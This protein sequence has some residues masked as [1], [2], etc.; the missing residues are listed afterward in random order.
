MGMERHVWKVSKM[1]AQRP[2]SGTERGRENIS[3]EIKLMNQNPPDTTTEP[4]SVDQQQACSAFVVVVGYPRNSIAGQYLEGP[5]DPE[6]V[7]RL[8]YGF[9]PDLAKAWPFL[10]ER[11]AMAKALIVDRHMGWG[12]GVLIAEP[13]DQAETPL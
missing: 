13:N 6:K 3:G 4:R 2:C 1:E 5:R 9:T 11:Q 10:T 12:E 8:G 7:K